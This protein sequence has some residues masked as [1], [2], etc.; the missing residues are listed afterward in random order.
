MPAAGYRTNSDGT[1]NYRGN[2]GYYWSSTEFGSFA[3]DLYFFNG[4]AGT[5]Y[6]YYR[7]LGLSVRCVAE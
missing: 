6:G 4:N 7:T 1:L 2:F 3:W 5:S